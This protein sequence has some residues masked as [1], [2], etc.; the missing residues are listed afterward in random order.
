VILASKLSLVLLGGFHARLGSDAPLFLGNNKAQALLAYLAIAPGSRHLR[1]KLATLFWPNTGDEHARQSLRQALVTLRRAL[2]THAILVADHREVALEKANVDIDVARFEALIVDSS[3]AALEAAAALYQGDLLEGIRVKEP[4]F[5]EWL[6]MERERLRELA[7]QGLLKLLTHQ[8]GSGPVGAAIRTAMRILAL[9]PAQEAVHRELMRLFQRQGRRGEALRQYRLCVDALQRELG[10]EPQPETRRLYQ[11][12][13]RS[14]R[15]P[16]GSADPSSTAPRTSCP[17]EPAQE[18][19]RAAAPLIGRDAELAFLGQA[20]D[21]AGRGQGRLA[22][23]LGEAGSGKSSLLEALESEAL[24]RGVRC[25]LGRAYL[26]GQVLAFAPW[27]D[28]LRAGD[29]VGNSELLARL[30][31]PWVDELA[32]LI[33]ELEAGSPERAGETGSQRL[34]EAVA[35]LV[36]CLAAEHPCLIMLEDIHWADEMSL[37]LLAFVARRIRTTRVLLVATV[38]E[39]EL[40]GTAILEQVLHELGA[41]PQVDRIH[42]SPLSREDTATLVRSLARADLDGGMLAR[43][44]EQ[45][46]ASSG[47]NPFL[48]VETMRALADGTVPHVSGGLALPERARQVIAGRLERLA[49]RTR[50]LLAAA[51]VIGREFDF[52]LVQGATGLDEAA[53]AEEIE[54]LV[55][56]RVLRVVGERFDFVHDQVREVVYGQLLPPRRAL[57]HAAVVRA[58]ERLQAARLREHVERLAHHAFCGELWEKAVAY[59]HQAGTIAAE[60]SASA[61][62]GACFDQ[63]LQALAR[64]PESRETLTQAIELRRVR[65]AHHFALGE[66]AGLLQRME[67]A[68]AL[69]ERLGD[70]RQL[71]INLGAWAMAFWFAGDNRRA[72]EQGRRAVVLAEAIGDAAA[73]LGTNVDLGTICS[74]VG[75]HH[76]AAGLLTR[77][78]ELLRDDL[79]CE[80]LGR[81]IYPSVHARNR[82]ARSQAELGEFDSAR[83]TVDESLRIAEALQHTMTLLVARLDACHV[84]LCRGHFHDAVPQLEACL[85]AFRPASLSIWVSTAAA[86]LGYARAMTGQPEDGIPFLR[87]ALEQLAQSRRTMEALFTTYLCE[88]HLLARQLGEAAV[89]AERALALS[90]ERFER[91]TEARALYLLGEIA[92]QGAEDHVADRHYSGALALA[93]ELGLRPLVAHCHVG[94]GNLYQSTG[95]RE[96]AQEHFSTAIAMYREMDM[97]FWLEKAE[98][99]MKSLPSNRLLG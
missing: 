62:A 60:R 86:M 39:E 27:I 11:E 1:D 42:L 7:L 31:P 89:V 12:V 72:L 6:Q 71:A 85:D 18:P 67:E 57:L 96:Q 54:T 24:R 59:G 50:S 74:S 88:A 51:S 23:V 65:S 97:R 82:L 63:A 75:D 40:A 36:A 80:R 47:G 44:A 92:A 69:A 56:R 90:R 78:M 64:L 35:R 22:L 25:H 49:E 37:R 48:V 10:V 58:I 68:V 66:R 61:Q 8:L 41:D 26:S 30:G 87:E 81:T 19:V 33:P 38:R 29:V 73:Q 32:R 13:V 53:A 17:A 94:L 91:A 55:R 95:K 76:A 46:F 83:A 99:A 98:Q 52:A 21:A 14:G 79:E 2:G 93:A 16:Q 3:V 45:I 77:A 34:F 70:K 15:V 9:D 28:A 43:L 20:L 5:D 4:P 84:L